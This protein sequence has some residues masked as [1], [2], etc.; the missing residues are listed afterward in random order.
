MKADG[1]RNSFADLYH[2]TTEYNF[3]GKSWRWALLSGTFVLISLIALFVNG[4]NLGIDFEGGTSWVVTVQGK[5]PNVTTVTDIMKPFNV[6]EAKVQ[7]LGGSIIRVQTKTVDKTVQAD[8]S[9]ALATYAGVPETSVSISN[10]GPTWGK[11]VTRNAIKALLVFFLV[12]AGYL[13]LRFEWR[14]AL[15]AIAAVVHDVVITVGVYALFQF[16]VTPATIVAFLT[17]LGFSLYDTVVVFDKVKENRILLGSHQA[18]TYSAMVNL[19]MNQVLMRSINTSL[20]AVLPVLSLLVVGVWV[21]GAQ[22]LVDFALAL[23]V[24]LITGAYSSIFVATPILNWM[25][26]REPA[27]RALTERYERE[28]ESLVPAAAVGPVDGMAPVSAS[29]APKSPGALA[30]RARKRKR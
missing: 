12:I 20:I 28:Q 24:G 9:K 8:I 22:S 14:M 29:D 11:Q 2:E 26:E 3:V 21:L 19:S 18:P 17:I 23:F 10:V 6:G 15:A 16:E 5:S 13:S 30:P 1:T 4:L 27:N 7:I 25:K